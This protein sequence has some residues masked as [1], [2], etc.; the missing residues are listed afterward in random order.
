MLKIRIPEKYI[1]V[2]FQVIDEN[3][4]VGAWRQVAYTKA[5]LSNS[6]FPLLP[7]AVAQETEKFWESAVMMGFLD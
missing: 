2:T 7:I 1:L 4:K 3:G 5:K 6:K